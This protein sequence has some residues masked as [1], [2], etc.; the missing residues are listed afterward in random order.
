MT[1]WLM[2]YL[3]QLGDRHWPIIELL[4][5]SL[6]LIHFHFSVLVEKKTIDQVPGLIF[7]K[8]GTNEDSD[9]H[10][11]VF[12][13]FGLH[14]TVFFVCFVLFLTNNCNM[15]KTWFEF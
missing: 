15:L 1:F 3:P 2:F 10:V 4:V 5:K 14:Y 9:E 7:Y 6:S 11:R 12:Q 13:C 8:E